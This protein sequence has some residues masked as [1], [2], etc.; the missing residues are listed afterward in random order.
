MCLP[1]RAYAAAF[2]IRSLLPHTRLPARASVTFLSRSANSG[3]RGRK[4]F[5]C[6]YTT[7][8]NKLYFYP[9]TVCIYVLYLHTNIVYVLIFVLYIFLR[10]YLFICIPRCIFG[11][12]S[13][14]SLDKIIYFNWQ[15]YIQ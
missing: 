14:R 7:N 9:S 8:S 10:M 2:F 15:C 11:A 3:I 12:S 5:N 4:S 1:T 6:C 13:S